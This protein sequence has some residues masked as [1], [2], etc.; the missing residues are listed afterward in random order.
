VL[1]AADAACAPDGADLVCELGTIDV[2]DSI[3]LD[4]DM[5][6]PA[7]LVFDSGSPVTITN[8]ATVTTT[9]DDP[10][11]ANDTAAV[12]VEA[13]AVADLEVASTDV[14][15]PPVEAVIGDDVVVTVR[16]A[17]GNLGPSSPMNA[18]LTA[19]ADPSAGLAVAPGA[20]VAAVPA[21][22][23]GAPQ[24]VDQLFTVQCTDPGAQSITFDTEIAPAEVA[25]IDPDLSNNA[26]EASFTIDCIVPIAINVRPANRFNRITVASNA[27]VPVAALTTSVGEYGLPAA[28][29]AS[30]IV[31]T[32]VRFGDPT[33]V[34]AG[35][36]GALVSG[37][38][39]V[40]DSFELDVKT[41]D[42]DDDMRLRFVASQT[43]LSAGDT[44]A[45]MRGQYLDGGVLYSFFGCDTVDAR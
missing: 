19:T 14:V 4:I 22:A 35:T 31:P 21:L 11:G 23:V 38:S 32:S 18:E 13:V 2:G 41:K 34:S 37:S 16:S 43:D 3:T 42:G 25:D 30:L 12:D 10:N 8:T 24:V 39:F 6:V 36:G 7:D 17:V 20:A 27:M 44:E 26:G 5:S 40:N 15:A 9:I 45:C 1:D 29:D 28:F 33:L